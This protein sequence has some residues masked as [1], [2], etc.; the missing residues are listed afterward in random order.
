MQ[1]FLG[2][3]PTGPQLTREWAARPTHVLRTSYMCPGT[4]T[5]EKLVESRENLGIEG[6]Q[7]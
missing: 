4:E 7:Q 3:L 2:L 5:V 1:L 6:F